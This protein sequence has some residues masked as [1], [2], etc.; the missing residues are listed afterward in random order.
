MEDR[1]NSKYKAEK[2]DELLERADTSVTYKPQTLTPEDQAQARENIGVTGYYST[3][4][5]EIGVSHENINSAYIWGLYDALMAEHPGK[6]QKNTIYNDDGT[7]TNYE[8]VISTGEYRTDGAFAQSLGADTDTK[9]PKY[10]VI[11]LGTNGVATL[12]ESGF[13]Y[14][15]NK[16]ITAI[17]QASPDTKI[18]VQS[19]YPVTSWYTGFT[20][21][22]INAANEWL[23]ELAE[24]A[25]VKYVDTASVLKGPDGA[26]KESFNSDHEDGYHVN[27][28]AYERILYYLRTHGYK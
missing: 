20:N 5:E 9:K 17:K 16:L 14:C 12:S 21:E 8:Y 4:R 27:A 18:I 28:D 24:E 23:L 22:K 25:G 6:V 3:K 19:I 10:L 11:S 13:K 1:Y 2:I 26:L 15:Y 7:F